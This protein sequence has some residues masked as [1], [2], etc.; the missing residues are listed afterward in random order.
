MGRAGDAVHGELGIDG[1]G[2]VHVGL[3]IAHGL[4]GGAV[5][6]ARGLARVQ[7]AKADQLPLQVGDLRGRGIAVDDLA[8]RP[9]RGVGPRGGRAHA[10]GLVVVVVVLVR[11]G[12]VVHPGKIR[13]LDG[14]ERRL[15]IGGGRGRGRRRPQRIRGQRGHDAG[16]GGGVES[17][18]EQAD[19][20]KDHHQ[21]G[22]RRAADDQRQLPPG[23]A[24]A[25]LFRLAVSGAGGGL[26][27][28]DV[29][30]AVLLKV[31]VALF[32]VLHGLDA[33]LEALHAALEGLLGPGHGRDG[34][35]VQAAGAVAR[36][37]FAD[38]QRGLALGVVGHV[39]DAA[40]VL[41]HG[42]PDEEAAVVEQRAGQK[43]YLR[44]G[45]AGIV[46]AMGADIAAAKI[47]KAVHALVFVCHW[48]HSFVFRKSAAAACVRANTSSIEPEPSSTRMRSGS[49]S[50]RAA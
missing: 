44:H 48:G 6:D 24:L 49:F 1:V 8:G 4:A 27:L 20:D 50:R 43:L 31:K 9:R 26:A 3:E 37:V 19:D 14:R 45:G 35:V 34:A 32:R 30:G 5:I 12:N 46:A 36:Q 21:H 33:G 11:A 17:V 23:A 18:G 39:D 47:L 40:G 15:H 29:G 22:H 42:A 7:P 2:A 13:V 25:L 10:A 16:R 41:P 38:A 28:G